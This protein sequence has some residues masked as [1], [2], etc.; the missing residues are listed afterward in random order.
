MHL[1]KKRWVFEDTNIT[2]KVN[3]YLLPRPGGLEVLGGPPACQLHALYP[4]SQSG[5]AGDGLPPD[6]VPGLGHTLESSL[7]VVGGAGVDLDHLLVHVLAE[8]GSLLGLGELRLEVGPHPDLAVHHAGLLELT[9]EVLQLEVG[10]LF[11]GRR[12]KVVARAGHLLLEE[13]NFF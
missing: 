5:R 13:T 12:L 10:G 9:Q 7:L 6:H 4:E 3:N 8:L 1:I 2:S 11:R